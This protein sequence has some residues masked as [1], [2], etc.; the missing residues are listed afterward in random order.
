MA[1][2]GAGSI[3]G[4]F[5]AGF[6]HPISGLDHIVAM[7]GVGLWGA[8]LGWPAIWLLPV[9]FPLVMTFGGI[10]GI[11]G[12][13]IPAVETGIAF[14]AIVLGACIALRFR[15]PLWIAGCIVG[16][17]A[18]FHGHAHGAEMPA[19]GAALGS[20]ETY[21]GSLRAERFASPGGLQAGQLH[22]YLA[23]R[24]LEPNQ[25]GFSGAWTDHGEAAVLGRAHGSILFRFHAR[26]LHLVLGPG[27]GPVRFRVRIDGQAPGANHGVDC[28]EQG[29][30]T[31]TEDRLYQLVRQHG[32]IA[33]HT[34]EIE[35]LDA[36]VQ[37]FA[38]T[39]G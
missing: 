37:A 22:L 23:P 2:T 29:L 14:S 16:C 3:S 20:P 1:H 38:F 32:P 26:D 27:S 15:A 36:G 13:P 17:F 7:V 6:E 9:V 25:W 8:F 18:I 11:V 24:K 12:V 28:D 21:V 31:V 4:G 10:L 19:D 5:L 39:F 34:F 35:F 30:G 33:D